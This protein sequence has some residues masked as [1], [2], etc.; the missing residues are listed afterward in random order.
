MSKVGGIKAHRNGETFEEL[1][2]MICQRY[3][4]NNIAFIEKSPEP[5]KPL[6]PLK[7]GHFVAYFVKAAQPDYK[8][9]LKGGRAVCFE[10]KHTNNERIE[11]KR[12]TPEQT[13]AL[14]KHE[15]LGALCF[16]LVSFSFTRFYRVPWNI[17]LNMKKHFNKVS[18]TPKD[19]EPYSIKIHDFLAGVYVE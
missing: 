19:L 10:A 4:M 6:K 13:D 1:I 18:V 9:T 2:S 11:Q 5:M 15:S 14:N 17:W 12:V 7:G 3:E 8:G 16:V